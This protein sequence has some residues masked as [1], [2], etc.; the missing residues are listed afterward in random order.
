MKRPQITLLVDPFNFE[1]DCLKAPLVSDEAASKLEMI[2]PCEEDKLKPALR[3]WTTEFWKSVPMEKYPNI[4]RAA[5][6]VLSM[7]GS[8]YICEYVFSTLNHVKSRHRSVLTDAHVKELLRVATTEYKP[9]LKK[10]VK[11]K[12]CQNSHGLSNMHDNK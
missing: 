7:F 9:D 4:K 3:K 11:E 8:T 5:V 10:I 1:T 6:K 2:N 12:E